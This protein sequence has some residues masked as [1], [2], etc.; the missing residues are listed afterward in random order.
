MTLL[1][2]KILCVHRVNS[3]ILKLSAFHYLNSGGDLFLG[4]LRPEPVCLNRVHGE[5]RKKRARHCAPLSIFLMRPG[6]FFMIP[7]GRAGRLV[8]V[9]LVSAFQEPPHPVD[10][11]GRGGFI[12][13]TCTQV[14]VN[15]H[16]TSFRRGRFGPGV[17][18]PHTPSP[19][20]PAG[21]EPLPVRCSPGPTADFSSGSLCNIWTGAE[22]V[23]GNF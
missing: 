22:F 1:W 17:A 23:N 14:P 2:C 19:P 16:R 6:I 11:R 12:F 7:L 5:R 20:A 8:P 3:S 15:L 18:L 9:F 21:C 10:H 13:R 4:G